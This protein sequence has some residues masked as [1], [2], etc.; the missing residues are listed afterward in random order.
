MELVGRA[1][2]HTLTVTGRWLDMTTLAG[3]LE[4][5]LTGVDEGLARVGA[6]IVMGFRE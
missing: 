2:T 6:N 3:E 1:G 5:L 4:R